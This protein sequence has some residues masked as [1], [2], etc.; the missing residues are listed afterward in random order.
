MRGPLDRSALQVLGAPAGTAAPSAADV[1]AWPGVAEAV[2]L[3]TC[4]RTE[5]YLVAHDVSLGLRSVSH[6]DL[7]AAHHLLRVACGL[8]SPLLGD[9]QIL[10]QVRRAYLAA[11]R[12]GATGPWLNRLFETALHAGK[13]VRH[14]TDLG[15]GATTT[16]AAAVGLAEHLAGGLAGRHVLVVGAGETAALAAR[17]AAHR[18]PAQ[19]VIANRTLARAEA[20][21]ARVQGVAI[22]L[23]DL[24]AAL[25]DADVAIT[26]TSAPGAV[27]HAAPLGALMAARGW[28][29]LVAVDLAVPGDIE[30]ACGAVAGVTRVGLERV[31]AEA[32]TDRITRAAAVP[33]AEAI[34][35]EALRAFRAWSERRAAYE[36]AA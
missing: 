17:H 29:P 27:I 30:P 21:A 3:A 19:L 16:A 36:S 11:R 28:R 7:P 13:R 8:D 12:A 20:V 31:E 1:R 18:R 14:H 6:A 33:A 34:A 32:A 2:V 23:D 26:A 10:G 35:S 9:G 4:H 22:G 24:R 5:I 25:A 15:R